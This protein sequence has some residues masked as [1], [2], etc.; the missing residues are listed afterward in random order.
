MNTYQQ[1]IL[2]LGEI[3]L[4]VEDAKIRLEDNQFI[5]E[6]SENA[7]IEIY[8]VSIINEA[9]NSVKVDDKEIKKSKKGYSFT[10]DFNN[11]A[12][13]ISFVF[14]DNIVDPLTLAIKYVEKSKEEWDEKEKI[15][16]WSQ[17]IPNAKINFSTGKDLVNIY[18][19]PA[20]VDYKKTVIELYMAKGKW[21]RH[22]GVMPGDQVFIPQLLSAEAEHLIGKFTVE[23]EMYFKA[24]TGLA[25]GAYGFRVSQYNDKDELL[26]TS[27]YE[28]F[29]IQNR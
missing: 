28:Y 29:G 7:H 21:S 17:L 13:E 19:Q 23:G 14:S 8:E 10:L 18:F 4:D 11:K 22:P 6:Q 20:T 16:R 27:D 2:E 3:K 24:I 1:R 9:I 12:N 5:I 25:N 26:F 15:S